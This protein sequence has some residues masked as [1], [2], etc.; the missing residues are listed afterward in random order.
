MRN[1]EA[2]VLRQTCIL[3]YSYPLV[4]PFD[5]DICRF[6]WRFAVQSFMRPKVVVVSDSPYEHR[7]VFQK[8]NVAGPGLCGYGAVACGEPVGAPA[9]VSP[10]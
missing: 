1:I 7:L 9:L 5:L 6:R 8:R 2:L 3:N 10:V 4:P